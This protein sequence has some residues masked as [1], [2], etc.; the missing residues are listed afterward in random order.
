MKSKLAVRVARLLGALA[1]MAIVSVLLVPRF[2]NRADTRLAISKTDVASL[3]SMLVQ[4]QLDCKRYPTTQEGLNALRVKPANAKGWKGPYAEKPIPL[5]EWGHAYVYAATTKDGKPSF[6]LM[7][8]G[9]D[10]APG[11]DGDAADITNG[12]D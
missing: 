11:G 1:I 5:D 8:Y 7:S 2:V 10:G 4:F 9:S 3:G 6:T 12:T